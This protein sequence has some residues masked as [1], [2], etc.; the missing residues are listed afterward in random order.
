MISQY[1]SCIFLDYEIFVSLTR[2]YLKLKYSNAKKEKKK[3]SEF[4]LNWVLHFVQR[5]PWA[6]KE[7]GKDNR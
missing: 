6:L 1:H 5:S 4:L 7:Q 3:A 2:L